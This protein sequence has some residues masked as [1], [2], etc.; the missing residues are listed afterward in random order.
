[1]RVLSDSIW[2]D[3]PDT[4]ISKELYIVFYQGGPID[5]FTQFPGPV[6]QSSSVSDY[7]T[8]C[9]LGMPLSHFSM[10]NNDFLNKDPDVVPEQAPLDILDIKSAVFMSNNGEDTKHTRQ[11]YRRMHFIR[12][13]KECNMHRPVWCDGGP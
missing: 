12:N 3:C 6:S 5:H 9:N 2:E 7:N 8:S 4:G 1:M 10:I 11:I 13:G